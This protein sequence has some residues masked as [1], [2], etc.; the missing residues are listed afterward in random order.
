MRIDEIEIETPCD[1]AWESMRRRVARA[2]G[3]LMPLGN[4]K[5]PTVVGDLRDVGDR[6]RFCDRC[7][8]NVYNIVALTRED[9][10]ALIA[11]SEDA[12]CVRLLRRRDGTV[13]TKDCP[14]ASSAS[15]VPVSIGTASYRP[16]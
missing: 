3:R 15:R 8:R 11:T 2:D 10:E 9:A 6:V 12:P 7:G 14:S 1:E 5:N 4:S 16:R 13:V